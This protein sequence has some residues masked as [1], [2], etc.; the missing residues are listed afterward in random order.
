LFS[1]SAPKAKKSPSADD[2]DVSILFVLL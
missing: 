2:D 1:L